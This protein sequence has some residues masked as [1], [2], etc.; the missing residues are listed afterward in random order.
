[1]SERDYPLTWKRPPQILTH[2]G[3]RWGLQIGFAIWLVLALSTLDPNWTRIAD[4]WER[5]MRFVYGF[6]QPNFSSRWRDISNGLVESLTMTLT[7]TVAGIVISVP[8]GIG[9]ARKGWLT[10]ADVVNTLP[11]GKIE[12]VLGKKLNT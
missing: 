11:L 7:S 1:M 8:I 5:G 6:I 4:G 9:A 10:R 2:R 3:W 12:K